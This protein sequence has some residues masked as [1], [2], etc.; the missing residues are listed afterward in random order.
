MLRLTCVASLVAVFSLA[1]FGCAKS[2]Y[3]LLISADSVGDLDSVRVRVLPTDHSRSLS[4]SGERPVHKSARELHTEPLRVAIPFQRETDVL[5]QIIAH[6]P[7]GTFVAT[8][9]YHIDGVV[10]D[11]VMLV[12][13]DAATADQDQDGFSPTPSSLCSDPDGAGGMVACDFACADTVAADCR[14][15]V[16]STC[17]SDPVD[18]SG[19]IYPGAP[20]FCEDGVDQDCSGADIACGD[21]D[22]DGSS[23]CRA[24]ATTGAC[25]CDDQDATRNPSASDVCGDGIDQNCDGRDAACDRDGDGYTADITIGGTPDCDDTN[26][27]INPGVTEICT[28]DGET[29]VDENCNGVADELSSCLKPDLDLDGFDVCPPGVTAG[30]DLNDCDPGVYPRAPEICGNG[31]DENCDGSAPMCSTGDVDDDGFA[32]MS[33]GGTDC[34][35][36][37]LEGASIHPGAG[38]RCDDGIDQ[39]CD[40]IDQ[41]CGS[42]DTDGDGYVG[43][44]DCDE[45]DATINA[46]VTADACNGAND[47]CDLT[48]DEVLVSMSDHGCVLTGRD[49][50]QPRAAIT[51]NTILHCGACRS[52]CNPGTALV[53]DACIA[54][55]GAGGALAC[56]CSGD[57][58]V[59]ACGGGRSDA[60]C[61]GQ[62]C[63]NLDTSMNSCGMC[64]RAC[65][66]ARADSCAGGNCACGSGPACTGS[67]VCCGGS[68][69][70]PST[71]VNNCGGCGNVCTPS[72]VP[73]AE[74]KCQSGE[75]AVR[76]CLDGWDDCSA[77]PGCESST[78]TAEHCGSCDATCPSGGTCATGECLP[79]TCPSGEAD[80]DGTGPGG[81]IRL[82]TNTNCHSCNTA[83]TIPNGVGDCSTGTCAVGTCTAGFADCDGIASNGC[84]A[85][86]LTD[87][88]HCGALCNACSNSAVHGT[89]ECRDGVC[90]AV[91][92]TCQA[93]FIDC[94]DEMPGCESV[95]MSSTCNECMAMCTSSIVHGT[96]SC[97]GG[98]CHATDCDMGYRDCDGNPSTI[99]CS[100][101]SLDTSCNEC[102]MPCTAA[103]V[104]GMPSCEGGVCHATGCDGSM[105]LMDCDSGAGVM[106]VSTRTL[107]DCGACGVPCS[108]LANTT[109]SCATGSCVNTCSPGFMECNSNP[110]DGCEPISLATTCNECGNI[111]VIP[112][113]TAS[114]AGG[115][116][117]VESCDVGYGNCDGDA[118]TCE[119]I[120][121]STQCGSSCTD[122]TTAGNVCCETSLGSGAYECRAS[123]S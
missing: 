3:S 40:G 29:P 21:N 116:C 11:T 69:V 112:N 95:D 90:E 27:S 28:P 113:A 58:A 48:T 73:H 49:S 13:L 77:A 81:C 103:M 35:D 47:D 6:G 104:G 107:T 17:P 74:I 89:A 37:L 68:C 97:M 80:C 72:D 102:G 63:V 79:N 105:G 67:D 96:A 82:N 9:C 45:G 78:R 14:G 15:C 118:N 115:M 108:G 7:A 86:I 39:D 36:S 50:G 56:D 117:H 75:C 31:V 44:G 5:V 110:A 30:C 83:C 92:G 64:G 60:C 120:S 84:E 4:V 99:T 98:F 32:S 43:A 94:D 57:S 8:R 76:S 52:S 87:T 119:T 55:P 88:A 111:C 91:A 122:C 26:A 123:C 24:T 114:C 106:C 65:E 1:S 22:G 101:E 51:F 71:D 25:D 34:N 33:V 109:P 41:P 19:I 18:F 46:G 20:E 100:V 70:A 12:A 16:G 23:A 66:S 59:R 62:G 54:D 42:D 53:A 2:E 85:N 38:D 121:A 93:G 61:P 10:R